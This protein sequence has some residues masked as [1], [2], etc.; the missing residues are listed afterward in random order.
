MRASLFLVTTLLLL[1]FCLHRCSIPEESP[2][3]ALIEGL[4]SPQQIADSLS[5]SDVMVAKWAIQDSKVVYSLPKSIDWQK[6]LES[7]KKINV[8]HRRFRGHYTV[9]DTKIGETRQVRFVANTSSQEVQKMA[10]HTIGSRVSYYLIEKHSS[11]FFS[12]SFIRFEFEPTSYSLELKQ[13]INFVFEN[14]SYVKGLILPAGD[15]YQ[16]SF[17]FGGVKAPVQAMI[18]FNKTSP[19]FYI[20]N[21]S[22][23]VGFN[24]FH[25][26]GDTFIYRSD[27]FDS[28]FRLINIADSVWSGEWVNRKNEVDQTIP[29]TLKKNIPFRFKPSVVPNLNISGDHALVFVHSDGAVDNPRVLRLSQ[30]HHYLKGSI[31]TKTGDYRYLE[32]V[33]RNDSFLLSTMDG[34]HAYFI[35]GRISKDSINGFFYSGPTKPTKWFIDPSK[36]PELTDPEKLTNK[37]GNKRFY[38]SFPDTNNEVVTLSDS[39][40]LNKPV[41]VSIMGTWCSN[42]ADEARFLKEAHRLYHKDGLRI[43]AIDFELIADSN[44]ALANIKRHVNSL[45]LDYPVLLGGLKSTKATTHD[46]FPSLSTV[47]SYPTMIVLNKHHD[48][49][50]IH[51]GFNGRATGPETFGLFRKE[52][53]S[54]FDSLIKED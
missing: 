51:T 4:P 45:N 44:R 36:S 47:L 22:E 2:S 3:E 50:K 23:R 34:T 42:C 19:S 41:V 49:I 54:L 53:L 13:K 11:S 32:G 9:T 24:Q 17:D 27:H 8:N 35:E 30:N 26:S 28:K 14:K 18:N 43:V 21:D 37:T 10:I 40:F 25:V 48:I 33:V 20:L 52:Y 15:L 12:E 7:L 1:E 46:I 5:R 38:F 6:E 29:V 31:L 16:I 39:T